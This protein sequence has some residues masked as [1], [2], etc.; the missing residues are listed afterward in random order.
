MSRRRV[1][2]QSWVQLN[3]LP[4][5]HCLP[6]KR[7]FPGAVGRSLSFNDAAGFETML[8]G[9]QDKLLADVEERE[10]RRNPLQQLHRKEQQRRTARTFHFV[11]PSSQQ[12]R[13][14]AG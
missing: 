5:S 9:L 11:Q 8:C 6:L 7:G 13:G 12:W 10:P 3:D 2:G 14:K 4:T 1:T